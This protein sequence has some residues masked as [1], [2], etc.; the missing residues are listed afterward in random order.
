MRIAIRVDASCSIGHGHVVRCLTLAE[1]LRKRDAEVVFVC[2][3]HEGHLCGLIKEQG[4]PIFRLPMMDAQCSDTRSHA[5]WLGASWQEDAEQTRV[6][7][8]ASGQNPDW[9]VVDHYGLDQRWE[10]SLRPYAARIMVIDDLADRVHDCD[11]L[12]DQNVVADIDTRYAG[13]VPRSCVLLLG[14]AYA[15]LQPLYAELHDRVLP[16]EGPIRHIFIYFGGADRSNLTG[17][18]LAAVMRLNRQDIDVDVVI[19]ADSPH[20][21][22]VLQQAAGH[23][24]IHIHRNLPTLASLMAGADLAIGAGGATSWERLC[25]GL[26]SLVVTLASNQLPVAV[27]L[28]NRGLIRW[29]GHADEVSE[30]RIANALQGFLNDGIPADWLSDHRHLVDGHGGRRVCESMRCEDM[31]ID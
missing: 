6:A 13:K 14:P 5:A 25:L 27:E 12:L 8:H 9:L 3:E 22:N 1:A 11:V 7:I 16:R 24:N 10:R 2:R 21:D 26:P 20:A 15:L 30:T 29:I 18:S 23:S 4:F 31:R 17:R 19:P 28:S